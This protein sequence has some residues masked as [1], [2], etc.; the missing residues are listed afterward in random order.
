[1]NTSA[2]LEDQKLTAVVQHGVASRWRQASPLETNNKRFKKMI[3]DYPF[4]SAGF[5]KP[6]SFK[7]SGAKQYTF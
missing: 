1:M 6:S 4:Y 2:K 5:S 3:Q 7:E